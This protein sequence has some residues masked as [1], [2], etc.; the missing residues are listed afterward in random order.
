MG[1]SHLR[2]LRAFAVIWT[3]LQIIRGLS[4][5]RGY[6]DPLTQHVPIQRS[7]SQYSTDLQ[8]CIQQIE[9]EED[10]THIQ[11]DLLIFGGL[12][13]RLDQTLHTLHVLWQ[14]APGVPVDDIISTGD[15]VAE[16]HKDGRLRKRPH[17][18]V[19]SDT[20][21]T[22][23]LSSGRHVLQHN[24]TILGKSCGILPLGISSA[25]IRT[26]GLEWNL[27]MYEALTPASQKSSLGGF[28]S[29]SNHL[30]PDNEAGIVLIETD[31]PV[32]WTVE[33]KPDAEPL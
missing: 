18:M 7:S 22:C 27:G 29:T 5:K 15:N 1:T 12:T 25:H 6:V 33:L 4:L 17:A 2:C 10:L 3:L 21:A 8:K 20:C 26:E 19:L 14:L 24:R 16:E 11:Y 31:A 32:Y 13:G 28:F 23:I 9:A 30:A